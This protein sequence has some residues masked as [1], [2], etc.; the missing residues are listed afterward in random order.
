MKLTI[1]RIEGF[2]SSFFRKASE[3]FKKKN[4]NKTIDFIR[5]AA[6]TRYSFFLG[7]KDDAIENLLKDLSNCLIRSNC[8]VRIDCKRCVV[9]DAFSMD[10]GGLIMQYINA[11]IANKYHIIYITEKAHF[12]SL[13]SEIRRSLESY[14]DSEI[15]MVPKDLMPFEK[16][17]FVYDAIIKTKADK[18][19][20]HT[21]PESVYA[22]VALYALPQDIKRYKINLTDHTFWVGAGCI[23]YS[24]EFRPWGRRITHEKRGLSKDRIYVV[25]FYPIMNHVG[26]LGFPESP[27]NKVVILSGGSYYKIFDEDDTFFKLSKSILDACPNAIILFA[28]TG[29]KMV[30]NRKLMQYSLTNRFIL[31][32]YRK[33]ITELFENCDIYIN[34]FPCSGGLMTQ[35]AAQKGKPIVG[36]YTH[37]TSKVE[38]FVCQRKWMELSFDSFEKVV[39]RMKVLTQSENERRKLGDE[40]RKCVITP[41]IFNELV[42]KCLE[43]K[44]ENLD[45]DADI[46]DKGNT[47]EANPSVKIEYEA[48]NKEFSRALVKSVGLSVVRH[49]PILFFDAIYNSVKRKSFGH[50]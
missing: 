33:D 9:Y 38:E 46:E 41:D 22:N 44:Y 11:L 3:S 47:H 16:A 6:F 26:F 18:I 1:K 4:Y 40:I 20:V 35:Y 12:L 2:Y 34:T 27:Q 49:I 15:I 48:S 50:I 13:K 29:D 21:A 30:M 36:F 14:G 7:Y 10:N 28:G 37:Y 42:E 31:L 25:P 8:S 45:S 17:Q 43:N 32:G 24:L 23:D 5:A 39:A 19:L